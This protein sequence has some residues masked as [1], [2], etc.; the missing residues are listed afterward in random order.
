GRPLVFL[1]VFLFSSGK[2][3]DIKSWKAFGVLVTAIFTL[4]CSE[5]GFEPV[6]HRFFW[7][8]Y[9]SMGAAREASNLMRRTQSLK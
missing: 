5:D 4:E 3:I 8:N 7:Y 1:C 9:Q 6:K 2:N